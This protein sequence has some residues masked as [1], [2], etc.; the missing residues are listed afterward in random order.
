MADRRAG[1]GLSRPAQRVLAGAAPT[2]DQSIDVARGI[3]IIAIVLGHVVLGLTAAG[4]QPFEHSE[5]VLRGLY[6]LRLPTLAYL[7]GLFISRGVARSGL[8]GF[9][10]SRLLMFGWLYVLWSVIQGVVK[11]LAGS[12][13]NS[14][15]SWGDVLRLWIPEGQ[16]W[17][18][19]WLM[20]VTMVAVVARP[21]A[22][23]T[24]AMLSV[25]GAGV[26]AIAVWGVEPMWVFTRGW[27]LLAP[28]MLGCAMTPKL[29]ARVFRPLVVSW[30]VVVVS[31]AIWL[32]VSMSAAAVPPTTGG[33]PRT[34]A[35]IALGVLG[36]I[37]G[38]AACLAL[39][40]LLAR[41]PVRAVL[42]PIG[43]RSLEIFL[44][45]IVVAAGA[46]V[47]LAEAGLGVPMVHLVL[48][49]ALGVLVPMA[50]AVLAER[51]G[52]RWVFGL[53]VVLRRARS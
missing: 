6:L 3:T 31:G 23:R 53:P 1:T 46:R 26:L 12:L 4:M 22:S 9:A 19:P 8:G 37:A 2:R 16:L 45:H 33:L 27:S 28:F 10:T 42:A 35:G 17:F 21:W 44:A 13:T 41:T 14:P 20:A 36:C 43:R 39:S 32:L 38:T 40:A 48:G 47:L 11:A 30:R 51:W 18:L 7:S 5:G 24:R 50:L 52:W 49:V 25:V 15:G 29:H 34:P